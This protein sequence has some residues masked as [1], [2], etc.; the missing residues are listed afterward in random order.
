MAPKEYYDGDF[1]MKEYVSG[2][3]NFDEMSNVSLVESVIVL[4]PNIFRLHVYP[5][6]T[7]RAQIIFIC[8]FLAFL[9]VPSVASIDIN[10]KNDG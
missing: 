4:S 1:T 5:R 3:S 6:F 10:P 9:Y 8:H 7:S 2:I